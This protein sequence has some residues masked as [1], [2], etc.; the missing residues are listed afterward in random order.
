MSITFIFRESECIIDELKDKI[1]E[2]TEK[3]AMFQTLLEESRADNEEEVQRLKD[4]LRGNFAGF[5]L[6]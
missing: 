3:L 5:F 2:A 1:E 4:Q 6:H